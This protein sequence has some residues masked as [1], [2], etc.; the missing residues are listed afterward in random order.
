MCPL[1]LILYNLIA[2]IAWLYGIRR[3]GTGSTFHNRGGH[4]SCLR[5][6]TRAI[7]RTIS[8]S[9]K[10]V[11]CY[12]SLYFS[13]YPGDVCSTTYCVDHDIYIY[14]PDSGQPV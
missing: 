11:Y 12:D 10:K 2:G 3:D 9:Y 1:L 7:N 14:A 4:V 6:T 8:V 13:P 5:N